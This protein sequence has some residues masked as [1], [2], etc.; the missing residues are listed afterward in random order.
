MDDDID[1]P[2]IAAEILI[3]LSNEESNAE[4]ASTPKRYRGGRYNADRSAVWDHFIPDEIKGGNKC[5]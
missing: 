1:S 4:M 3:S 2:N 5:R